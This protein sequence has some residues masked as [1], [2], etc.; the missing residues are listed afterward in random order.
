V[1]LE[2]IADLCGHFGTAV[3]EAVYRHELRPVVLA[4]AGV[5][6]SLFGRDEMPDT[7]C[8]TRMQKGH[9]RSCGCAL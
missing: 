5:M 7:R 2:D 9:I 1:S 4:G 6:N 8:H 3:T